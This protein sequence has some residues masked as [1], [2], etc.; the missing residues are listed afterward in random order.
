MHKK[1]PNIL[2][3]V[4]NYFPADIRVRKE[5]YH[6]RERMCISVIALKKKSEKYFE[7]DGDIII[8]RIP[9]LPDMKLGKIRYILEYFYFTFVAVCIFLCSAPFKKY[10]VV[11]VHNPPDTLF[12]VG[13]LSKL[14][15]MKFIFDHHD[16]SPNLYMSRFSGKKDLIYN[17]LIKC[18]R[19]SC[20]LADAIIA[21]NATYKE[22]EQ[23]RHNVNSDK[24]FIVRNNPILKDCQLDADDIKNSMVVNKKNDKKILLFIGA[25]NPQDG[26]DELLQALHYLVHN[27]NEKN[28][29]C[30]VVGGGDSLASM[31]QATT[32]MELDEYVNFTGVIYDRE[33]IK[34]YLYL[35]D[36]GVEPAPKN[37]LNI[38]ST[39]IKVM[40]YMAAEKPIVAFDLKET[41][42]STGGSALLTEPG[43]I[44]GFAKHIQQLLHDEKLSKELGLAGFARIRNEL[45][46]DC[47]AKIL[48][49]TYSTL[50][51]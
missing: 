19:F 2:M 51:C 43:D 4:E 47:A 42:Y 10:R 14:F 36:I 30:N 26:V 44:V 37:E 6:L 22:I 23:E 27:L 12:V 17:T 18:E 29:I 31:R 28:F 35:A 5:A 32:K 41:R 20:K 1:K 33:K 11:H 49:E 45:N 8:Y 7:K 40:E 38:H 48:D 46:W 34:E 21:T 24:I 3:I 39:F 50:S 15:G 25:I 16:L 9:E 13:L